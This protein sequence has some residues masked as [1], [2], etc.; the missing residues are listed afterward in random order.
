MRQGAGDG[1]G[2]GMF[3]VVLRLS[4][5]LAALTRN[6]EFPSCGIGSGGAAAA[7]CYMTLGVAEVRSPASREAGWEVL[8]RILTLAAS[9]V[10]FGV[11]SQQGV[12]FLTAFPIVDVALLIRSIGGM[13]LIAP[14]GRAKR[15]SLSVFRKTSLQT[16]PSPVK[17]E[18]EVTADV[19][20]TTGFCILLRFLQAKGLPGG[21]TRWT[22]CRAR[23]KGDGSV[24]RPWCRTGLA[25]S[26]EHPAWTDPAGNMVCMPCTRVSDGLTAEVC[27]MLRDAV[28]KDAAIGTWSGSVSALLPAIGSAERSWLQGG[29]AESSWLSVTPAGEILVACSV[30]PVSDYGMLSSGA[31]SGLV[32][33]SV[34]ELFVAC[35]EF[36][37]IGLEVTTWGV[38]VRV[39]A[40]E[41]QEGDAPALPGLRRFVATSKDEACIC[42]VAIGEHE[43]MLRVRVFRMRSVRG[44]KECIATGSFAMP[45]DAEAL[46]GTVRIALSPSA[47]ASPLGK[48][49]PRGFVVMSLSARSAPSTSGAGRASMRSP[50]SVD[51][52]MFEGSEC[53]DS[54]FGNSASMV[55]PESSKRRSAHNSASRNSLHDA[56]NGQDPVEQWVKDSSGHRLASPNNLEGVLAPVSAH[57]VRHYKDPHDGHTVF[58]CRCQMPEGGAWEIRRRFRDFQQLHERVRTAV[59]SVKDPARLPRRHLFGNSSE[60]VV[61]QRRVDLEE[62]LRRAIEILAPHGLGS[63]NVD[64]ASPWFSLASFL[65]MP[66][67]GLPDVAE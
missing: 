64:E 35:D 29:H 61:S 54:A 10:L 66:K 5:V 57:I 39:V 47:S 48:A 2:H 45:R 27:L 33:G 4:L 25:P 65:Q 23:L 18:G 8:L 59:E 43:E 37:M 9:C 28:G 34:E 7:M 1:T 13:D 50:G 49:G 24:S 42:S 16:T 53:A 44:D 41:Q 30:V 55:T 51:G 19:A 3:F 58:V 12:A 62:Y 22:L 52:S 17:S 31:T 46:D 36:D 56:Q 32:E 6:L 60:R 20:E 11:C 21:S 15:R 40:T 67:P 14:S 38:Q 63:C 26:G